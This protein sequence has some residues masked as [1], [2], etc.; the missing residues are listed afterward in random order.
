MT[1]ATSSQFQHWMLEQQD[2]VE[3]AL[4][5]MLPAADHAP[6][7]LH[8]AMRYAALGG[9][10]RIRPLLAYAA[11]E[12]VS[13]EP[14]RVDSVACAVELIHAYSL[15]HDDMPCMDDDSLRR[16]RP[17]VHVKFDEATALLVGDALQ[18]LAFEALG[19]SIA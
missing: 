6:A 3:N 8:S 7:G 17:T 19:L 11:G 5:A 10:K 12:L 9:G 13:A 2:R 15:V 18:S 4:D 16:G 1:A 14:L